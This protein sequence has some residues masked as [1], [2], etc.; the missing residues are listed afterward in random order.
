MSAIR[1][2]IVVVACLVLSSGATVAQE[3]A[4]APEMSPEMAASMAAWEAAGKLGAEH[5]ELAATAGRWDVTSTMWMP[6]TPEATV[7]TGVAE[8]TLALG[9]R[10]LVEQFRSE[11]MGQPFEGIAHTGYDNVTKRWWSTWSD[12]MSTSV[13]LLHGDSK[14]ETTDEFSG[15]MIDPVGGLPIAMR[16]VIETTADRE[17]HTFYETHTGAAEVKSMELVYVR[18]K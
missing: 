6:G 8:R 5:E 10:V 3:A 11:V 2:A 12:T 1:L 9:G 7:S 13:I 16:I 17:V 4:E 15:T 14:T 18:K